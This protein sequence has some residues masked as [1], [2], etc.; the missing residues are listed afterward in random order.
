MIKAAILLV[1]AQACTVAAL[2]QT[3]QG[4]E[5]PFIC[6][7]VGV[8]DQ[9]RMKAAARDY[10]LMLTFAAANGAYLADVDVEIRNSKGAVILAARCDG[11]IMLVDLPAGGSWRVTAQTNGQARHKTISAGTG[12]TAQAT[13]VWPAGA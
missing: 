10:D 2:A 13:F 11:P 7:G 3:Q 4:T 5:T 9:Q 6:G 1:L 12:R 8:D